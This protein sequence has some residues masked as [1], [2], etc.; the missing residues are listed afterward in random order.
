MWC[1][2][3]LLGKPT[4]TTS[5][6]DFDAV[7]GIAARNMD[8]TAVRHIPKLNYGHIILRSLPDWSS[9]RLLLLKLLGFSKTL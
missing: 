8:P 3:A 2:V 6:T 5:V 9:K 1:S 7:S 4:Q